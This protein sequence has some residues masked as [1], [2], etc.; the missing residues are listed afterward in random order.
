MPQIYVS[1]EGW[2]AASG[3]RFRFWKQ[4]AVAR[5]SS[6]RLRQYISRRQKMQDKFLDVGFKIGGLQSILDRV[7]K[8]V[9]S[10]E[11]RYRWAATPTELKGTFACI[12]EKE[13]NAIGIY[14]A[15]PATTSGGNASRSAPGRWRCAPRKGTGKW[16]AWRDS[17]VP[18]H[19]G[20][21]EPSGQHHYGRQQLRVLSGEWPERSGRSPF[22]SARTFTMRGPAVFKN[23]VATKIRAGSSGA[24]CL[25][26]RISASSPT[27]M[28]DRLRIGGTAIP[29]GRLMTGHRSRG[30]PSVVRRGTGERPFNVQFTQQRQAPRLSLHFGSVYVILILPCDSRKVAQAGR[31]RRR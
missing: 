18:A 30:A 8:G 24:S 28:P 22:Q 31:H 16:I 13:R 9:R 2:M 19:A 5:H 29:A 27:V 12:K 15:K 26:E 4:P 10:G 11:R 1:S 21:R 3:G 7:K 23:G 17:R 20:S 6:D 25:K 14:A